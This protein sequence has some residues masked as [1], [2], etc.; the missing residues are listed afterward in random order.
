MTYAPTR[1]L[2][3]GLSTL[4][5]VALSLGSLGCTGGSSSGG[6]GGSAA[7]GTGGSS[8]GTGGSGTGT[9]GNASGT[10]GSVGTGGSGSGTGGNV[11]TGGSPGTGGSVS[12]G[13]V[14]GTGGS[15]TG[16]SIGSTGG[17]TGT[18]GSAGKSG[19]GGTT[20]TGGSVVAGQCPANA[21]FC[22]TFEDGQLPGGATFYPAYQQSTMSTYVSVDATVGA[23]GSGHS[24]KVTPG[25]NFSQMLGVPTTVS[26]FWA[27]MYI[28]S[29]IDTSTVSGHDTFVAG[30]DD[31][32][33]GGTLT[34]AGDPN[35]GEAIRIGEHECQLEINRKSD[36]KEVLSDAVNGTSNYTCAGGVT[37][38]KDVWY[39]LEIFYDG[40]NSAVQV[41][42]NGTEATGLAVTGWGPY[43]YDMFKFGF[44]NYGG[45]ARNIWY[46]DVAITKSKIG[47]F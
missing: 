20:G 33:N 28:R 26:S 9:G 3:L 7:T 18:G 45:T 42:V 46:D 14:S 43:N 23:N 19:T 15:G 6:T 25:S 11:S 47:C 13:G 10:G 32:A 38:S 36:D 31:S 21:I 44:E 17:S 24:L 39:C 29:D 2:A 35:N 12:T 40:P 30:I 4:S 1:R 41:Y 8:S 22:A 27:T 16:G 34:D 37:F 5:L